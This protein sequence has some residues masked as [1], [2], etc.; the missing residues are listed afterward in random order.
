MSLRPYWTLVTRRCLLAAESGFNSRWFHVSFVED[1]GALEPF[2]RFPLLVGTPPLCHTS[3]FIIPQVCGN[4][5]QATHCNIISCGLHLSEPEL[6]RSQ[7]FSSHDLRK[8][9]LDI[10]S[11]YKQYGCTDDGAANSRQNILICFNTDFKHRGERGVVPDL[12]SLYYVPL[13]ARSA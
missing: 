8:H 11:G 1:K 13:F 6:G 2:L 7:L 3:T 10:T 5:G 12:R 4:S 9:S